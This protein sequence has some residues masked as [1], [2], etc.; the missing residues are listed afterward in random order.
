MTLLVM[1]LVVLGAARTETDAEKQPDVA[2]PAPSEDWQR[3]S[4]PKPGEWL[5]AFD[6]PGQTFEE[7]RRFV[8]HPRQQER[9]TIQVI[10]LG[11]ISQEHP[12]LLGCLERY[13]GIFFDAREK[14]VSPRRMPGSC[15]DERRGQYDAA[16]L[17][18]TV[19]EPI[20][21][22]RDDVLATI[23]LT[24]VDLYH[25]RLNFVFGIGD[26]RKRLGLCSVHRFLPRREGEQSLA[27]VRTLKTSTHE[28]GHMLGMR[29]CTF[30]HCLMNGSNSLAES[31]RRPLFLC[32]VCVRKMEWHLG[33]D[34][35][36]R[37][38]RMKQFFEECALEQQAAFCARRIQELSA[39]ERAS[40]EAAAAPENRD[41]PPAEGSIQ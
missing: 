15:Y 8:R 27:L 13:L 19:L 34:R 5:Y 38:E 18:S 2:P 10:P 39:D 4:S 22:G 30:Y 31:D 12:D 32:P 25:G 35:R 37:Y 14:Q 1:A 20:A 7:Y 36:E 16:L 21:R 6:E 23:G 28:I 40:G 9:D 29:H 3:L 26:H 17:L 24:E 33:F 11:Q 41:H